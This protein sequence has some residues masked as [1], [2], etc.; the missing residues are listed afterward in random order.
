MI[1]TVLLGPPLQHPSKMAIQARDQPE[2][3]EL[4]NGI[5]TERGNAGAR[6][7]VKPAPRPS[8]SRRLRVMLHR[9]SWERKA[10]VAAVEG[11][12]ESGE[13][14]NERMGRTR[15]LSVAWLG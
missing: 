13:T 11:Y 4:A 2:T 6:A 12:G 5:E 14:K 3:A 9:E 15:R 10:A 1:L 8:T 7:T